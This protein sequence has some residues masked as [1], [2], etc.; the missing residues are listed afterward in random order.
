MTLGRVVTTVM[1]EPTL[2]VNVHGTEPDAIVR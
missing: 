2:I 1:L